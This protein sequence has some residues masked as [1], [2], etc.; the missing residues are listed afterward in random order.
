MG[1]YLELFGDW[2]WQLTPNREA[3][4]K[5]GLH[6]KDVLD[7][8]KKVG[9]FGTMSDSDIFDSPNMAKSELVFIAVFL[10]WN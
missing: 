4:P 10:V 2:K 1:T 8:E 9:L 7:L 5:C 3:E 6:F